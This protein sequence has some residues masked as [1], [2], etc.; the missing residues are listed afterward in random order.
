MNLDNPYYNKLTAL[1]LGRHLTAPY[2]L[3]EELDKRTILENILTFDVSGFSISLWFDLFTLMF[4]YYPFKLSIV[5]HY[6]GNFGLLVNGTK[7]SI[8]C[9][10]SIS[11]QLITS[12]KIIEQ[13]AL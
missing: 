5:K 3:N 8:N 4:P 9:A 6:I 13:Y 12:Y 2:K 11:C 7:G 10:S 1:C